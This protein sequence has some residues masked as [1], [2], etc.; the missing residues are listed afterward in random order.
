MD[1]SVSNIGYIASENYIDISQWGCTNTEVIGAEA[2][3]IGSGYQ[4]TQDIINSD[5]GSVQ[6]AALTCVNYNDGYNDWFLPSLDEL[7]LIYE[8]LYQT[9]IV[10]YNTGNSQNWYWSSTEGTN[11]SSNL[12]I[13]QTDTSFTQITSIL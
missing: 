11:S 12:T 10:T 1:D 7:N 6:S 9:G 8:N 5:C 13:N 3:A 2:T 4:N